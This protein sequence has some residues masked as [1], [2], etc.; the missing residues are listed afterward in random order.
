MAKNRGKQSSS[1]TPHVSSPWRTWMPTLG[2]GYGILTTVPSNAFCSNRPSWWS[3]VVLFASPTL[4]TLLELATYVVKVRMS[5]TSL[6]E[7]RMMNLMREVR[8]DQATLKAL[9]A[10]LSSAL[11]GAHSNLELHLG[12][13]PLR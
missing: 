10:M 9:L 8:S 11:A 1:V 12:P 7:T 5:R 3:L 6:A 13:M 2:A 4:F